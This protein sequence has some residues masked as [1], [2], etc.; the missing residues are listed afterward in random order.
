MLFV[1]PQPCKRSEFSYQI[2]P[3][4]LPFASHWLLSAL[5]VASNAADSLLQHGLR[6]EGVHCASATGTGLGRPGE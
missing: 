4:S 6:S 2:L 1:N 3:P 5:E